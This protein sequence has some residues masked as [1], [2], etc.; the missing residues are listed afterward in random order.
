[1][2]CSPLSGRGPTTSSGTRLWPII[3]DRLADQ[4]T[5]AASALAEGIAKKSPL[6][7]A[8]TLEAL[9]RARDASSLEEVLD[10]E[11]RVS[12]HASMTNDFAEGIRAQVIDKDRNP[13]WSPSELADVTDAEVAEFFAPLPT[14]TWACTRRVA[15]GKSK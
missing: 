10:Q 14:E 9:R 1:M 5:A 2:A 8:V 15:N 4:A 3:L 7:L 6:A 13:R 12:R 11:Y